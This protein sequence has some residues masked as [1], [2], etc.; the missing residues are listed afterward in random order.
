MSDDPSYNRERIGDELRRYVFERDLKVCRYCGE[1][2][3]P[4][5]IDHVYPVSKGG[6]TSYRNLVTACAKCNL[7]KHNS[8]GIWPKPIGYF[9]KKYNLINKHAVIHFVGMIIGSLGLLL[10]VLLMNQYFIIFSVLGLA[11][12]LTVFSKKELE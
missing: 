1:D 2:V 7:K 5:H 9:T 3:P 6:E 8:V 10:S 11:V 12:V 4:F